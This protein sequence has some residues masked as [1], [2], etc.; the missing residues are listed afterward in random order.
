M[1]G[2][3]LKWTVKFRGKLKLFEKAGRGVKVYWGRE[4]LGL[5]S[6][7][8]FKNMRRLFKYP[9]AFRSLFNRIKRGVQVVQNLK[10]YYKIIYNRNG[11]LKISYRF[12]FF[13]FKGRGDLSNPNQFFIYKNKNL[14]SMVQL[15]NG[16]YKIF[17][18]QGSFNFRKFLTAKLKRTTMKKLG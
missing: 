12:K 18:N 9:K 8:T 14:K 5:L 7:D 16:E 13:R 17:Y 10:N 2:N 3:K 6:G 15:K 11:S 1:R 4:K